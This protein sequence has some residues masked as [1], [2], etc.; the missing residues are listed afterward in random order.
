MKNNQKIILKPWGYEEIWANTQNYAAKV[1]HIDSGKRLSLQYHVQKEE[2]VR[3]LSGKLMVISGRNKSQLETHILRAGE[4]FHVEPG[5]IHR[6]CAHEG[7]VEILEV[8]TPHLGDVVR[9]DDDHGRI[10]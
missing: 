9:I 4:T 5:L 6:F 2:T 3:V 10:L 7:P 8:S 1:L